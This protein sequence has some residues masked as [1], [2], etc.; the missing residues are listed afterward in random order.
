MYVGNI[1]L[2]EEEADD[3]LLEDVV[4]AQV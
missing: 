4:V 1:E 3:W 2:L